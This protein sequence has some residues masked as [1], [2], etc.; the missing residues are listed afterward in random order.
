MGIY[1][2]TFFLSVCL[3]LLFNRGRTKIS[4]QNGH[5]RYLPVLVASIPPLLIS[6][7]RYGV[8]T[9]YFPTYY[10][11]FYR[12]L[13]DVRFDKFE[14][15]YWT[16]NKIILLFTENVFV[17]F[18]VTSMFF[19]GFSYVAMGYLSDNIA[20]SI[21]L[22]ML[23]RYYFIGMN[24]VRQLIALAVFA[25]AMRFV[26]KRDVKLYLLFSCI[27]ISFHISTIVLLP[28]YWFVE[29]IIRPRQVVLLCLILLLGGNIFLN[30][31]SLLFSNNSKYGLILTNFDTAGSFFI[32]GTIC[33]NIFF[34]YI[35]FSGYRKRKNSYKY[36]CFLWLQVLAT[37][38]TMLLPSIPVVER[39]YWSFSFCSFI[40]LPYMLKGIRIPALRTVVTFVLIVGLAFYM[41]YDIAIL[42]DHG[43]VPYDSI[44]GHNPVPSIDFSFR[45]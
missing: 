40:A 38:S 39:V 12:I 27:A 32:V 37:M 5:A 1:F 21:L 35:Y 34:L 6:A 20:F 4:L 11:G 31:V 16:L 29:F 13:A 3:F 26:I 8:G 24:A 9:D 17:L 19:V 10:T 22:F 2:A 43:V 36:R 15:G 23:M 28:I 7:L 45:S 33:I 44:I 14:I 42:G 41:F 25:Y 30:I 18:F